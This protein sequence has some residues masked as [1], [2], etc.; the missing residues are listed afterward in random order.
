MVCGWKGVEFISAL[1]IRTP[2]FTASMAARSETFHDCIDVSTEASKALAL[3]LTSATAAVKSNNAEKAAAALINIATATDK[4]ANTVARAAYLISA[5][6][7]SSTVS[8]P[9]IVDSL[10]FLSASEEIKAACGQ[11]ADPGSTKSQIL[12][13]ASAIAKNTSLLCTQCKTSS[14]DSRVDMAAKQQFL[15]SAKSLAAAT[16]ALVAGIKALATSGN[17][18]TRA[19]CTRLSDGLQQAV[20]SLVVFAQSPEFAP[21]TGSISPHA[22]QKQQPLLDANRTI[23]EASR[24]LVSSIK[25]M[26][27]GQ[28]AADTQ[29]A[30]AASIHLCTDGIRELATAMRASAPGQ[31]ECDDA[32]EMITASL[33]QVESALLLFGV[34]NL[35]V[36]TPGSSQQDDGAMA[37][38]ERNLKD[39]LTDNIK[40]LLA[41][42]PL[43]VSAAQGRATE[44]SSAAMAPA[45]MGVMLLQ[46][47]ENFGP[48]C[49]AD[50]PFSC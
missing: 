22:L 32:I 46:L 36:D 35:S 4:L 10:P 41:L 31:K 44:N 1:I 33:G 50:G 42:V 15:N 24:A 43:I 30:M 16:T 40:A 5:A 19:E 37:M 29:R 9:G 18:E 11:L 38:N 3:G 45:Q 48:V 27:L 20:D 14:Q 13:A 8:M 6:D 21:T 7:P 23:I 39:T 2:F 17:D 28:S 25:D 12:A 34:E 47:A 49:C 26:A